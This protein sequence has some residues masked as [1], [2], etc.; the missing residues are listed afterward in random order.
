M[1]EKIKAQID[2][3][4]NAQEDL[5]SNRLIKII[6]KKYKILTFF[7][8]LIFLFLSVTVTLVLWI[9]N[10]NLRQDE[11]LD[12]L[13]YKFE[14]MPNP[15]S[16]G[17]I[18]LI[19]KKSND[20][21][22]SEINKELSSINEKLNEID[23]FINSQPKPISEGKIGLIFD[24]KIQD[25]TTDLEN[26]INQTHSS[27]DSFSSMSKKNEQ[28][29]KEIQ[30]GLR[31]LEV[32]FEK[33]SKDMV[34]MEIQDKVT[35]EISDSMSIKNDKVS[36]ISSLKAENENQINK[37]NTSENFYSIINQF[38]DFAYKAIKEDLKTNSETGL[39][40]SIIHNFQLIFVQRSLTPQV[41]DS[42]DAILSRAE[43]ALNNKNYEKVFSELNKLPDEASSVM[44]EWRNIFEVYLENNS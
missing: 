29:I 39:I 7:S 8:L 44:D 33:I 37:V 31:S 41:G 22:V 3:S 40:N 23:K 43:H 18:G 4:I 9:Y 35:K 2:N 5:K 34:S 12:K 38:S 13:S 17:R 28:I 19:I 14:T 20:A 36:N 16:Q 42:V 15:I 10:S 27:N 11:L 25:I 26:K 24:K 6:F 1:S 21:L 30:V 32:S